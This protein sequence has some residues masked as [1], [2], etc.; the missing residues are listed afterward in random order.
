M[1]EKIRR[2]GTLIFVKKYAT[3]VVFIMCILYK[4]CYLCILYLLCKMYRMC[5]I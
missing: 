2:I 1:G 5:K 3:G 4:V